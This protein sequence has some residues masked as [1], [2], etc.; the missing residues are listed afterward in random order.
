M[1][2]GREKLNDLKS[3]SNYRHEA[4]WNSVPSSWQSG[5]SSKYTEVFFFPE[6][7]LKVPDRE[8][9]WTD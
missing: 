1:Y 5:T 2:E 8:R 3:V 7:E 6:E 4:L 9:I